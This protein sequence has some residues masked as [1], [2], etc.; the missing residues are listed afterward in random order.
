MIQFDTYF[1]N[2]LVQPPT[3][4]TQNGSSKWHRND[5]GWFLNLSVSSPG[6]DFLEVLE[7]EPEV[8]GKGRLRGGWVP[9]SQATRG[10][11]F[12][13]GKK[14]QILKNSVGNVAPKDKKAYRN[15]GFESVWIHSE[16]VSFQTD[17]ELGQ[18][19]NVQNH[20]WF[21]ASN[22]RLIHPSNPSR[23]SHHSHSVSTAS[24]H[25][26]RAR[27]APVSIAQNHW[28]TGETG[29]PQK[30]WNLW[31]LTQPFGERVN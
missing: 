25:P 6:S 8:G 10:R 19:A 12:R 16:K 1:S 28:I 30:W 11:G 27:V 17:S 4:K 18:T 9:G 26:W 3:S 2:G 23:D 15:R 22:A 29:R 24:F 7:L 31:F 5:P 13:K 20:M 14:T 21:D